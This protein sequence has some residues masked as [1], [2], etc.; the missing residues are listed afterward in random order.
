MRLVLADS[1]ILKDSISII[2]ELVN[3]AKFRISKDGL[4]LVAMDPAS[5]A[6]V[7]FKLLSSGFSEYSIDK[8][9][10]IALSLGNLKQILKRSGANDT[11]VLELSPDNKLLIELRGE[12]RRVFSIPIVDFEEKEQKIPNLN[13]AA[14]IQL[15]STLLNDAIED[16]GIVAE[17]VTFV[18]EPEKLSVFAEGDLAKANIEI[19]AGPATRISL[20]KPRIKAKYSIEY[21]K[22][23]IAGS[24]LADTAALSFNQDY[25]L[26]LEYK[27]IDK[28]FLAF[29]LA[30]R[31][32]S[33]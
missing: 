1:S 8:E 2:S 30:P 10:H 3:E 27:I 9:H 20:E 21:L 19:K 26:Q 4:E 18:A 16:A 33:E 24:K 15:P 7:I 25:P 22:K 32:E 28:L 6:M 12:S 11:I 31:V 17:A 14:T 5:V 29:I 13:F 23:M